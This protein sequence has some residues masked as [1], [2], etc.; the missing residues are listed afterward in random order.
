MAKEPKTTQIGL[1]IDTELLSKVDELAEYD[2]CDR[3]TW[4]RQAIADRIDEIDEEMDD[5]AIEDFIHARVSEEDFKKAM[6]WKKIPEDLKQARADTL[7]YL[8]SKRKEDK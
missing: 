7:K 1:R 6:D 4:I 5:V 3:M 2:K 8:V